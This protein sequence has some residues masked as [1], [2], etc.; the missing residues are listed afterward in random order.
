LINRYLGKVDIILVYSVLQYV[1]LEGNVWDFFDK[2]LTLL[3]PGGQLLIGDIPNISKRKRFFSS[4]NGKA[5]HKKLIGF[6]ESPIVE[7]NRIEEHQIDDS[8][9][10]SL[11][12]R[13]RFQ[14]FNSYLL[15]QNLNLPM[16]NRRE[17]LLIIRN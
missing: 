15:P 17:D 6:D 14:G 16:A 11:L 7:F 12:L 9:L 2:A 10:I 1:F 5:F 13:A 8:V 3:A 4:E